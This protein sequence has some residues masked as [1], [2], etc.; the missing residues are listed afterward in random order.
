M[1]SILLDD[2]MQNGEDSKT[3]HFMI[4]WFMDIHTNTLSP[5]MASELPG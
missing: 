2:V 5:N 3:H 4:P 1:V